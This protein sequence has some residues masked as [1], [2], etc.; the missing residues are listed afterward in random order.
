MSHGPL[1]TA[2]HPDPAYDS[3]GFMVPPAQPST[4]FYPVGSFHLC[5]PQHKGLFS[6]KAAALLGRNQG[7][8][9][10]VQAESYSCRLLPTVSSAWPV[11]A[12]WPGHNSK[13]EL[14]RRGG[15]QQCGVYGLWR[16]LC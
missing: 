16:G 8:E 9:A 2:P 7:K 6:S 4:C 15:S 5:W 10:L 3:L 1:P 13:L 14:P 12:E 11:R